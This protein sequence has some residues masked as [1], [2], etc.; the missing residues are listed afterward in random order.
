MHAL[1][2]QFTL[3]HRALK[4]SRSIRPRAADATF[5]ALRFTA[6]VSESRGSRPLCMHELLLCLRKGC[7]LGA[8][9]ALFAEPAVQLSQNIQQS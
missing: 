3:S 2:S 1:A 8:V 4:S 6:Y 9:G 5:P 7:Y